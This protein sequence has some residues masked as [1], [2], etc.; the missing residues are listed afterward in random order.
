MNLEEYFETKN[1][2]DF[3]SEKDY[4]AIYRTF[5]QFMN[6]EIHNEV[7]AIT[8]RLDNTVY[9]NDHSANH[10]KMVMVKVSSILKDCSYL[11]PYECFILL[12]AI[13]IHD[14]GHIFNGRDGHEKSGR[15]LLENLNVDT[16]ER[17]IIGDIAKAHSGKNDPIGN[18]PYKTSIS[19]HDVRIRELAALLRF[20]DELA[21]ENSRASSYLLKK[22]LIPNCIMLSL[23]V[24]TTSIQ[25]KKV[26]VFRW[27]FL[28]LRIKFKIDIRKVS[29]L[30]ICWM[31][32]I[33]EHSRHSRNVCTI[34]VLLAMSINSIRLLFL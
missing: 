20:G 14:A 11:T 13:Q 19:G 21:D 22:D 30:F 12:V 5:K 7:K 23:K 1:S 28:S 25:I 2:Q 6:S 9:L 33:Q 17:K 29:L 18:L 15:Y 3:P 27:A 26:I 10:V 34:I 31:K 32:Y 24:C 8:T 4:V 16:I